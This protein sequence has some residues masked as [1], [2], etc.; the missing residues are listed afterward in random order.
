MDVTIDMPGL[1]PYKIADFPSDFIVLIEPALTRYENKTKLKLCRYGKT[2]T[3]ISESMEASIDMA[4]EIIIGCIIKKESL[5]N[6]WI[7]GCC[8]R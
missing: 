8:E 1:R 6:Q 3:N 5:L 4:E 2:N 7:Y